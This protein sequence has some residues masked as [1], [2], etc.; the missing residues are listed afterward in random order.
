MREVLVVGS[1]KVGK[2]VVHRD[3]IQLMVGG[4]VVWCGAVWYVTLRILFL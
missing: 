1:K 4:G 3:L 2:E